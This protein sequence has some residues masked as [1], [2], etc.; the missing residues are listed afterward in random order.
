MF[1]GDAGF[2]EKFAGE[3]VG[4]GIFVDYAR[5]A[6]VDDHFGADGAGLMGA[7]KSRSVHGDAEFRRLDDGVLFRM[8]GVAK[9]LT[10]AAGDAHLVAH[11]LALVAAVEDAG[12]RAV[13][14][15]GEDALVLDDDGAD[16]ASFSGA[17]RPCRDELATSSHISINRLSHLSIC[18]SEHLS[19]PAYDNTSRRRLQQENARHPRNGEY[20]KRGD[21]AKMSLRE[22]EGAPCGHE[23][24]LA[25]AKNSPQTE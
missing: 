7:V 11:T 8:D 5:D 14:A 25:G 24:R 20:G 16:G 19:H 13:V 21:A 22:C 12:G 2:R 1:D 15:R 4:I 17:A 3:F 9:L 6:G 18:P 23:G 10:G